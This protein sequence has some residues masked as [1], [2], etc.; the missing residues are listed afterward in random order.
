MENL[1]INYKN[2]MHQRCIFLQQD[3]LQLDD[4]LY[5]LESEMENLISITTKF[6]ILRQQIL[7]SQKELRLMKQELTMRKKKLIKMDLLTK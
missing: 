6:K 5:T 7:N 3:I 2:Y 1:E 4:Q